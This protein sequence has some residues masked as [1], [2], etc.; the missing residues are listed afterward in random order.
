MERRNFFTTLGIAVCIVVLGRILFQDS[1][2]GSQ[3]SVVAAF[4]IGLTL[5]NVLDARERSRK[6]GKS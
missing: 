1:A 2:A 4:A 3:L 6:R 5:L